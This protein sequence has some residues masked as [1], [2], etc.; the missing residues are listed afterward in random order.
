MV[1]AYDPRAIRRDVGDD[2]DRP[3]AWDRRRQSL[4]KGPGYLSR[5]IQGHSP[6]AVAEMAES[7]EIEGWFSDL[8]PDEVIESVV[9]RILDIF[10]DVE[11]GPDPVPFG[12]CSRF[13]RAI[14]VTPVPQ[15]SDIH[16]GCESTARYQI[17]VQWEAGYEDRRGNVVCE[18]SVAGVVAEHSQ[19]FVERWAWP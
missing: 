4:R 2:L 9:G 8:P 6:A 14:S 5:S 11:I 15:G 13:A 1:G 12:E 7:V 17:T 10:V 18:H 16:C 3:F 19:A